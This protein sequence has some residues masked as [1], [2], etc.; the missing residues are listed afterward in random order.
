MK[1]LRATLENLDE[2]AGLFDRYRQF[3]EQA[4]NPDGCRAFIEARMKNLESIIFAA[5][6][7]DGRL[8]GF[9]QLYHSFCSVD[10]TELVYLY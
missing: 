9:T 7:A 6:A 4:A 2:V 1:I 10:M 3:Y 5:Q 8:V